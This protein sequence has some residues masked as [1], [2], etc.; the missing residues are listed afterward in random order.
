MFQYQNIQCVV[1]GV[2][3]MNFFYLCFIVCFALSKLTRYY[4]H[5]KSNL[6]GVCDFLSSLIQR[7]RQM[8][9]FSTESPTGC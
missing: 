9:S 3:A 4:S 2:E 7:W 8:F 5:R 1:L 6:L